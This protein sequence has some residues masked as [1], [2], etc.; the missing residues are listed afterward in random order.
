MVKNVKG[1][2]KG[3]SK[4]IDDKRKTRENVILLLKEVGYL[5]TQD[6]E[7][8]EVLRASFTPVFTSK[9]RSS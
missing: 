7:K 9:A 3:H 5:L 1:D 4:Y 2:K 8:A 6:M